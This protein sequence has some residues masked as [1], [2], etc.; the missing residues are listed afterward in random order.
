MFSYTLDSLE[1]TQKLAFFLAKQLPTGSLLLLTGPLGAGKTTLTQ[2]LVKALESPAQAA[3][4]T[5]T[6]I[7]EYPSPEGLLVHID[8]Y[9]LE[10]TEALLELGLEDYLDYARLVIVEWGEDLKKIFPD[11]IQVQLEFTESGRLA[12]ILGLDASLILS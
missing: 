8:A 2:E 11:A 6:L 10:R 12:T 1:E 7:H 5:Y 4:P 3:S 9:R